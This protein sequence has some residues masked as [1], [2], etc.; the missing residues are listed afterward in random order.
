MMLS[1]L[2]ESARR[3]EKGK[4]KLQKLNERGDNQGCGA[5][6]QAILNGWSRSW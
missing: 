4:L 6:A 2:R 3:F 1:Y 5:G